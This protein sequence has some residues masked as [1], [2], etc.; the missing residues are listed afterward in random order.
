[1]AVSLAM[2]EAV[3]SDMTKDVGFTMRFEYIPPEIEPIAHGSNI[4]RFG[5]SSYKNQSR[6]PLLRGE[7]PETLIHI[8][9]KR[10]ACAITRG[11]SIVRF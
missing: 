1:M 7:C 6:M 4:R 10:S 8:L 2:K 3:F 5:T 11:E 9:L